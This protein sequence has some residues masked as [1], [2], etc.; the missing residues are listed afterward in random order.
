MSTNTEHVEE[1]ETNTSIL[2]TWDDWYHIPVIGAVI[3]FMLWV[4]LQSYSAFTTEDGTPSLAAVDSWYHWR[5]IEW[6]AE[7]YPYTMPYDI[8]T[9]FP[10][11]RYVGQFG[12]LFDQLIVTVAMIVGLG[13]PSTETLYTVSLI[14]VPVMA[15]L[16]AIPVFYIGRRLG[17][18]LGGIVSI[19]LLALVPGQFLTRTTVGQLQHHVAEVLFMAIAILALMVALR[20]A[21]REQ[22]IYELLVDKDWETL[23]EPTIYS[24]LAGLALSLYIWVWPPG[25]VLIGILAIFFTVQLCLDYVRNI[26]PDHVAFVG[27]TSLGITALVTALLIE[28]PGTSVT[29][30]SYLQ[31]LSAALVAGGCVFM[32]WFARQWNG[33]D[34]DRRFYPAAIGGLL[35]V[36]FGLMWVVLPDLFSTIVDNATR[37]VLPFGETATDLTIQE[38]QPPSD[39]TS[40]MFDEFGAAFYTMLAGLGLLIARP[41]LGREYRTEYT[42]II[43]WSLFLMSMAATQIRFSYYLVLAVVAMNAVFVADVVRLFDFDIR[44]GVNSIRQIETYQV[45]VLFMVALLLFAPLLPPIAQAGNTAWEQGSYAQPHDDATTWEE[46]NHWLAENT[47]EPGNWGGADNASELDYFGSYDYPEDGNFD[48]PVGSYGVMSWW[49]YGHLI[50][51]QSERIPHSN[52]FQQNARSSSAFL[53]A[54]SEER[55]E[56]ILDAIA[57]G[58][59][60]DDHSDEELE[61]LI[62]DADQ[63]DEEIRY[64]MIDDAM[65][66]GKFSAITTWSEPDHSHYVTPEDYDGTE[67]IDRDE[68]AEMFNDVPY[69]DTVLSSLY[70]N[71]AV[72]MENYR[73]VHEN[74]EHATQFMSYAIINSDTDQVLT[75]EDGT[76]QVRLNQDLSSQHTLLELQQI[77]QHPNLEYEEIG[78]RETA[79]VKTYERVEGATLSGTVDDE[80]VSAG[81]IVTATLE[82]ETNTGTT[83]N[84]TQQGEVDE[85][86]AFELTV[87]YATDDELGVEDGYTNSAVEALDDEYELSFTMS[88]GETFTVYQGAQEVSESAVIDGETLD[89]ELEE[90]ETE[91]EEPA[92]DDEDET[93][94][95]DEEG[96]DDTVADEEAADDETDDI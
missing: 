25:V 10:T 15:A 78:Q 81:D 42:L 52:P 79:S 16:V 40:F 46:S 87:P 60:V 54:E 92:D 33:F 65:A 86:G 75:A 96:G 2:E 45:I 24:A 83:F 80:N 19:L 90:V 50:T 49:D 94:D 35:A 37:R 53:T 18:T 70:F 58:E 14:A 55:A 57:T 76:P 4:R 62:A 67:Q 21:E 82:I 38:A 12:T 29:S 11:G 27:A 36:T 6:T 43:V 85:N 68:V 84:Y 73:L 56:L 20:A 22:P 23:R 30:F 7:N 59:S 61:Q 71:N 74:E 93:A 26:S 1:E 47:P 39:F 34:V 95:D 77:Q 69:D 48:Y 17:G 89:V 28:D 51:T 9:G 88:D 63:T 13:D 66:S 3:L 72:G 31:P 41:F 5:T 91:D 44:S 64:V 32:A 8:W